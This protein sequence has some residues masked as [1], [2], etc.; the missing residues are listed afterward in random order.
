MGRE[1]TRCAWW[2]ERRS[3]DAAVGVAA[4]R[5]VP[6]WRSAGIMLW[7]LD[8]SLNLDLEILGF[9]RAPV[10]WVGG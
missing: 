5:C 1:S 6:I 8:F 4:E 3:G 7:R 9:D 2:D 10:P